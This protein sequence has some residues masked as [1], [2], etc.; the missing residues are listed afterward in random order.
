MFSQAEDFQENIAQYKSIAINFF[1][2]WREWNK[3][4]TLNFCIQSFHY[5]DSIRKACKAEI[6]AAILFQCCQE[7]SA[8]NDERI[9]SILDVLML[10]SY[11][12]ILQN[13]VKTYC[14]EDRSEEGVQFLR[15]LKSHGYVEK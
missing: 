10:P 8:L 4:R 9:E 5:S 2:Q 12:Y 6:L 3:T 7:K 13:Y 1:D 14:Y 15:I 11:Q